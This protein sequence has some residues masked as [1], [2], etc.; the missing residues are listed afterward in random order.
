MEQ[1]DVPEVHYLNLH[2]YISL[3][4]LRCFESAW[5]GVSSWCS[6]YIIGCGSKWPQRCLEFV[7]ILNV[8]WKPKSVVPCATLF[9]PD[10]VN[11]RHFRLTSWKLMKEP[12]NLLNKWLV[13]RVHPWYIPITYLSLSLVCHMFQ[14]GLPKPSTLT[15]SDFISFLKVLTHD[16]KWHLQR[17]WMYAK[18]PPSRS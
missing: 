18:N 5:Q 11:S 9:C 3:L 14:P 15:D 16:S 2:V 7:G 17:I 6:C 13:I 12:P 1:N 4:S 10:I 8:T